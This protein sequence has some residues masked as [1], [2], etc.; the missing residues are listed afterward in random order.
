VATSVLIA[1]L[2]CSLLGATLRSA[3]AT[4]AAPSS[5]APSGAA[6]SGAAP[7][8]SLKKTNFGLAPGTGFY[9]DEQHIRSGLD[10]FKKLG[11]R[12]LRSSVP[13]Q[14][15]QPTEHGF[16]WKGVD[17]LMSTLSLPQYK[18]RFSLIVNIDSPPKWAMAPSRIGHIACPD[19]AP[20]D[21]PSYARAI[22]ALAAHMKGT[23]HVFELEN[24][25]NIGKRSPKHADPIAVWPTPNPCGY[26]QLLKLTAAAVHK[27]NIGAT[28]LVGGIGGTRTVAGE[29]M[30]ADLFL[31]YLYAYGAKGHFD[32]VS[33]HAYSTPNLP[34]S[35]KDKIC[36][37]NPNPS[38]KDPYGLTN[39]WDRMLNARRVMVAYHDSAT[40]IWI[41]EFGAPT[42]GARGG[43]K[44]LTEQQQATL[45]TAG[46][47]RASQYSWIA[48]MSWFTY[49]DKGG[50]MKSDPGGGWMGILR[51]DGS[52]KPSYGAYQRLTA[53]AR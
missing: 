28:V 46:F 44:M 15:F 1:G 39:G 48:E 23:A 33:Y 11:V 5:T 16:N 14:N 31:Y 51:Q 10:D 22:A 27:L 24:S 32:G 47:Q 13:W 9:L 52:R 12:W 6:A 36:V 41:T 8:Y 45:L 40:K 50:N 18:G 4:G 37:F 42:D 26:A 25:P 29:R 43:G 2:G 34:C 53:S 49:D 21:L 20:F 7:S 17:G 38:H 3:G 19:P 30:A 35:P